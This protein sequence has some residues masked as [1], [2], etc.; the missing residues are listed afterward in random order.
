MD[1]NLKIAVVSMGAEVLVWSP[2][3]AQV[4]Q[5]LRSRLTASPFVD[6]PLLP[7]GAKILIAASGGQDSQCLLHL[8]HDLQ[9]KWQWQ[10]R[11]VH[12][13][14]RWRDDA[15]ANADF[16][17]EQAH[18]LGL[19]CQVRVAAAP[20]R[21]EAAARQWRYQMFAEVAN[22]D[23]C[24]HVV[25]GHTASDRAETLL[26]NLVRGSGIDGLQALTWQ[27]SLSE[28]ASHISLVRPLLNLTRAQTLQ[29]CEAF[30]IPVW[31]DATNQDPTYRRNRLRLEVLPRLRE[32]FN[33]QLD[34]TLAH[35]AE[36]LGAEA[37]FLNAETARWMEQCVASGKLQRRSLRQAPLALQR[38]VIRQVLSAQL[39]ISP[40]FDHVEKVVTLLHAPNRSQTDPF[41]GGTIAIVNDPWIVLKAPDAPESASTDTASG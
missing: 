19:S 33:P 12:C 37:D 39:A 1:S 34:M 18:W 25:T 10:L 24:T 27:R 30:Q 4:H 38:R 6:A 5:A 32:H 2:L 28:D 31:E 17:A 15:Q 41:P 26:F 22:E 7:A 21:S 36:L 3:H 40:Q 16:V 20:P 23:G 13:N 29:F 8:L 14:H 35:T 9:A 11:V